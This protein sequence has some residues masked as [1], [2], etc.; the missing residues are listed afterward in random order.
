MF[1]CDINGML[2]LCVLPEVTETEFAKYKGTFGDK[3]SGKLDAK[4]GSVNICLEGQ[5]SSKL[6]SFFGTLKKE[7]LAVTQLVEDSKNR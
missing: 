3:L 7:E 2:M 6:Q 5:G 4:G 1:S